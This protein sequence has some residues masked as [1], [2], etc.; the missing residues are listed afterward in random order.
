MTR[1]HTLSRSPWFSQPILCKLWRMTY[2]IGKPCI[3]VMD[4]ACVDIHPDERVVRASR[5]VQSMRFITTTTCG[6]S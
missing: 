6:R 5:Y 4:R 3:D 1:H 2:V